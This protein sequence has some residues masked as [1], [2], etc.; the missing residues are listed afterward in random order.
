MNPRW[1]LQS[2]RKVGRA[3]KR[4]LNA[5]ESP[6]F[7]TDDV[8]VGKRVRF[9]EN[10]EFN[11][12]RVRI[13]DGVFVGDN[14]RID[15]EVFEI[16]DYGTI[17]D[18]CFFPGP[19]EVSIG[20]NFWLGAA[21]IVDSQG[22]TTIGNNVGVG[23]HSQLWTH[24]KFGDIMAGSRF[25]SSAPL[26][27]EDD[28]WL[29]G[30]CLVSPVTIGAWSLA[31]LGS[32]VTRDMQPNRSYAGVP[33]KDVTDALGA[34]FSPVPADERIAF[35]EERVRRFADEFARPEIFERV[36][37]LAEEPQD[38]KS[39]ADVTEFNV[40]SRTYRKSGTE[41]EHDFIRYLLPEAKFV[42]VE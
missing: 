13:G 11:C 21:S 36:R 14:V 10:V 42:P 31:M 34:P 9:G 19:G 16:G 29:V 17:Y 38:T 23:A 26:V 1:L 6:R 7:S 8:T 12:G 20:H 37:I 24:M 4:L 39:S 25:H 15:A 2:I 22:G 18:N 5:S 41:L 40:V 35:L 3:G 33:A 32:M 28:A 30:H 27:I